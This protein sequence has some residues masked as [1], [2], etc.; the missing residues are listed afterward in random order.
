MAATLLLAAGLYHLALAAFHLAFWRLFAW[1]R[2]LRHLQP[3]NRAIMQVLNI[4]LTFVFLFAAYLALFHAPPLLTTDLGRALLAGGT[5]FW[6][7]RA[8]QQ[9]LFFRLRHPASILFFVVTLLG[10][11]LCA[12][13]LFLA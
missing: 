10:A 7:L 5:L 9:V 6:L 13:P 4:S 12:T 11:T 3:V 1:P 2:D 8:A